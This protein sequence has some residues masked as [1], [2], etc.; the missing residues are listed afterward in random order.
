MTSM[1]LAALFWLGLHL[2]VAGP[3]RSSLV[4]KLGENAFRGAFSLLSFAGLVWFVVAY[5]N[6]PWVFLWQTPPALGWLAIAFVFL[7]FVLVVVGIG[8]TNATDTNA[9]RV[10]D[11]RLPV[12]GV[13]RVTR[14]PRLCGISLWAIA[15]ML[16]NGHLAA[17]LMFGSLLVTALYGMVSI[18]RKRRRMLAEVWDEFE[19]QTSRLP[20]AAILTG[21]TRFELAEFH[22]WQI[23]LAVALFSGVFW[24]HGIIG[25]S[26]L[27]VLQ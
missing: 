22:L 15:H 9:P 27:Y 8:S 10:I 17:F 7:G 4:D 6:A 21:R 19:A 14:H 13:T 23:A 2:I 20:F 16:V 11:S 5:R 1:S 18:D 24:L 12:Y 3:L 25:P 26:P